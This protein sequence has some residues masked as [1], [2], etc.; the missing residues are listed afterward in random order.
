MVEPNEPSGNA[1]PPPNP[2]GTGLTYAVLGIGYGIPLGMIYA[3]GKELFGA[4]S[5]SNVEFLLCYVAG[6]VIASVR[7]KGENIFR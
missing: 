2:L 3:V 5:I 6:V 7:K 4:G 1:G